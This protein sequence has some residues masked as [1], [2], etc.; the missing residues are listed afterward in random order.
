MSRMHGTKDFWLAALRA[1][2]P[3]FQAAVAAAAPDGD[4]PVPTCPGLDRRRPRPTTSARSTAGS[5][6]TVSRG[7]HQ[8]AG[9]AVRRRGRGRA[10][11]AG[12]GRLVG[13]R[14]HRPAGAAR[15][16]RPGDARVELGA[17]AEEGRLLAPADGARDRRAPVGRA[18]RRRR[19]RADRGQARRRRRQRGA[20]HLAARPAARK[21]P[22]DRHGVVHLAATDVAQEWYVRLRGEGVALLDTDTLLDSDDHHTRAQAVGTASDLLLALYGRVQF[23]VVDVTGDASLLP[24]LRTG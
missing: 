3:A 6:R 17:P 8:R 9:A 2:G 24:A 1:D 12:H 7:R 20:R 15:R 23:D 14:V 5:G 22:T 4:T 13:R 18:V 19:G 10:G 11:L 21:G 16:A